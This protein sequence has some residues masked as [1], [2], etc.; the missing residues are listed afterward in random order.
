MV[1]FVHFCPKHGLKQPSIFLV[2]ANVKL[3]TNDA[4]C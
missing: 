1:D 2:C 3:G 4:L